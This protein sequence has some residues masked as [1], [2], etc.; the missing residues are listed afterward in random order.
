MYKRQEIT[1]AYPYFYGT[2]FGSNSL[3]D[4]ARSKLQV[5]FGNNPLETRMS[6]GGLT[7]TTLETKKAS[8]V[9]TIIID[10]RYSETAVDLADEWVALRPGT[11]AAL[12]G[13]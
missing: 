13:A 1:T 2:W 11:D 6:G 4:A 10:P 8:G 7:F 5:M 12:V 9:R 3:D